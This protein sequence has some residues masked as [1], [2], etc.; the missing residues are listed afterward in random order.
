MKQIITFFVYSNFFIAVCAVL[1]VNQTYTL[2]LHTSADNYLLGFVF[3]ATICSYSFHWYLTS[4][5]EIP[6]ERIGW[7]N[8]FRHIH[9]Y[10]FIISIA[11][12]AFFFF[13][14]L[15]HWLWL[16]LSAIITFL[17]SA[18]KIPQK[19]F[20]ALR[21]IAI[22]KTIFLAFVWMY[23]TTILPVIISGKPWQPDILLFILSRFF[24][25]Y[26][27]CILF[28]Y[29][30]RKDDKAT[31]IR[32]M[33]TYLSEKGINLLFT[34]SLIVFIFSSLS[35]LYYNYSIKAV[36]FLLIPGIL[37]GLLYNYA[38]QN[39]TDLFFYLVLDGLMMLSALLMIVFGI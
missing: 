12:A 4:H 7:T 35:L 10:L 34:S 27:I 8:K 39:F 21:K 16:S 20:R 37:T 13:H 9:A 36:I 18:P 17:Y 24:L 32:S 26:A 15:H 2:V 22:G 29:R 11:G 3:F 31:G 6:S 33:I 25:I 23:A 28:D 30:D 38:K 1:M 19:Y 14:L 5:S